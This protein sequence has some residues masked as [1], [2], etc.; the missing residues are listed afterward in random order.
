M[1]ALTDTNAVSY[2]LVTPYYSAARSN[3]VP[4]RSYGTGISWNGTINENSVAG[5]L[6]VRP[7][8]SLSDDVYFD[9]SGTWNDPYVVS[10]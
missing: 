9:G 6:G 1:P 5:T 8:I 3:N 7:V 4:A 10:E 2:W